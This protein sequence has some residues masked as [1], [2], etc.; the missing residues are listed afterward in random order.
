[1]VSHDALASKVNHWE[2]DPLK[3]RVQYILNKPVPSSTV[4]DH[5]LWR[6][7]KPLAEMSLQVCVHYGQLL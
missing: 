1:M 4:D 3:D 5:A 2:V 6:E 7:D